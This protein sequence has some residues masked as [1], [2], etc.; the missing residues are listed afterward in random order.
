[1]TSHSCSRCSWLVLRSETGHSPFPAMNQRIA[2]EDEFLTRDTGG[3]VWHFVWPIEY[4]ASDGDCELLQA[5]IGSLRDL[6]CDDKI[7]G[8]VF[9]PSRRGVR[10]PEIEIAVETELLSSVELFELMRPC[11]HSWQLFTQSDSPC[12]EWIPTR[13]VQLQPDSEDTYALVKSWINECVAK[14][15]PTQHDAHALPS[16]NRKLSKA[17]TPSSTYTP[18]RLLK[19]ELKDSA[20][21]ISLIHT[22]ANTCNIEPYLA[23]SYCWGGDQP[24]KTTKMSLDKSNGTIDYHLLPRTL[25]D[26]C[27]V[28]QK[29]GYSYLWVDSLCII[30]DDEDEMQKEIAN[31]KLIYGNAVLTI[32]A[33]RAVSCSD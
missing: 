33:S 26:A 17:C 4:N 7:V 11:T 30:Q 27:K 16:N 31:M 14:H 2:E 21:D 20:W 12:S 22:G 24:F 5:F 6:P 3:Y 18:L 15:V 32:V 1:M 25:Q 29:L 10:L 13:P 9:A 23:L 28:T 8:K 19:V